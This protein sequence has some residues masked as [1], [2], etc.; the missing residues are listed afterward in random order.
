MALQLNAS[1]A[2]YFL[3]TAANMSAMANSL[4]PRQ[5]T[6]PPWCHP[7][8]PSL[9]GG[10][11]GKPNPFWQSKL[12]QLGLGD[13]APLPSCPDSVSA[14]EGILSHPNFKAAEQHWHVRLARR[15]AEKEQ[16]QQ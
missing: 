7:G 8:P 4:A 3:E 16:Q 13:P 15:A 2:E 11:A 6:T 1:I 12:Q 10:E 9:R 5:E 14:R